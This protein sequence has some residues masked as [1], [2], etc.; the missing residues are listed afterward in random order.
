MRRGR[1]A[2]ARYVNFVVSSENV[3]G[4]NV[5]GVFHVTHSDRA[6]KA[7]AIGTRSGVA[8][9]VVVSVDWLAAPKHRSGILQNERDEKAFNPGL[10]LFEERVAA[11]ERLLPGNSETKPGLEGGVVGRDVTTPG[12]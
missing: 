9:N 5:V 11:Q 12:A 2:A 3:L 8:D 4:G 6:A 1:V 10:L 7:V